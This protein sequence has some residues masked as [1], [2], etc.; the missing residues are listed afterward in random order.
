VIRELKTFLAVVKRGTFAA[1]GQQVGLTQSA[2]SAQIKNLE[3][4]LG[5]ALFD[6]SARAA[7]LN[8]AGQRAV[9]MAEQILALFAGMATPNSL[10]RCCAYA[11]R[12][13]PSRRS[14]CRGCR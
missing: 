5:M 10:E 11:R 7:S 13:R 9:P 3:D 12:H 14:W 1:A 6:R 8:A 4:A 2:V